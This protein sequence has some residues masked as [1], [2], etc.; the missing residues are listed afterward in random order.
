MAL[1]TDHDTVLATQSL[2]DALGTYERQSLGVPQSLNAIRA[3]GIGSSSDLPLATATSVTSTD[4]SDLLALMACVPT[5]TQSSPAQFDLVTSIAPLRAGLVN[6]TRWTTDG[7]LFRANAVLQHGNGENWYLLHDGLGTV[8]QCDR[9]MRPMRA[10]RFD[11]FGLAAGQTMA[12]LV[13]GTTRAFVTG[14]VRA[15]DGALYHLV[16]SQN[17]ATLRSQT[18]GGVVT[19]AVESAVSEAFALANGCYATRHR[20]QPVQGAARTVLCVFGPDHVPLS[21]VEN[22][23]TDDV[24]FVSSGTGYTSAP[25]CALAQQW[26]PLQVTLTP[27]FAVD[28]A[29]L[30]GK[31]DEQGTVLLSTNATSGNS[32]ASCLAANFTHRWTIELFAGGW[33]LLAMSPAAVLLGNQTAAPGLQ[34]L[35]LL[36]RGSG[37]VLHSHYFASSAS[38]AIHAQFANDGLSYVLAAQSVST[39]FVVAASGNQ[40]LHAFEVATQNPIPVGSITHDAATDLF[41]LP[42][43]DGRTLFA[44]ASALANS[45]ASLPCLPLV[46]LE[47]LP[48]SAN[49]WQMDVQTTS[50]PS[51]PKLPRAASEPLPLSLSGTAVRIELLANDVPATPICR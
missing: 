37:A 21:I 46:T 48:L 3:F 49:P 42:L 10:L 25:I 20:V 34:G 40:P 15:Q 43:V 13:L 8:V 5:A 51:L 32:M 18:F 1:R 44:S 23:T 27:A 19:G 16:V 35:I 45:A 39:R 11:G 6:A 4:R 41:T 50:V 12:P 26:Q 7:G 28:G 31:I 29:G 33:T 17:G 9:A 47:A 36:D 24:A 14:G 22:G 2:T 38:S 30:R